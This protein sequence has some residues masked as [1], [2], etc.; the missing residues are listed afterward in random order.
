MVFISKVIAQFFTTPI[1]LN[2]S[3]RSGNIYA[4][5]DNGFIFQ[6]F[7]LTSWNVHTT[8]DILYRCPANALNVYAAHPQC[9]IPD[10]CT[11]LNHE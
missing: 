10:R 5:H 1:T 11:Q 7:G 3:Q 9:I 6:S 2:H 8:M 4:S